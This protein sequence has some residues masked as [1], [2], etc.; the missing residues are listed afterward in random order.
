M[1]WV[2][3]LQAG[4]W[5]IRLAEARGG[6]AGARVLPTAIRT[7]AVNAALANGMFAHADETDD[8]EPFTKAHPGCAVVPAA[9]AVAERHDRSG[10]ELL[11]GVTL[12]YD[13]CCRWLMALGPA[14]VRATHRSAEGVSAT[15]GAAAAAASMGRL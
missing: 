4:E 14:H 5:G 11:T 2:S 8:F 12:G 13:L 15:V 7:P 3:H 6:P 9:L 1:V 10:L